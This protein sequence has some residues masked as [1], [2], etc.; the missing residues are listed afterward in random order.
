VILPMAY[1]YFGL[2]PA[3]SAMAVEKSTFIQ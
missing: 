3:G 2:P 1:V